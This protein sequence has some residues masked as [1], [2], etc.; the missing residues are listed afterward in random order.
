VA[1]GLGDIDRMHQRGEPVP[2]SL[3]V[4]VELRTAKAQVG[5]VDTVLNA[6]TRLFDVGGASALQEDRRLDRHWRNART[7]ASH[8]P[9]IYK[10]RAVGDHAINGT[11]PTFYWAVGSRAES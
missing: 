6:A 7:L 10:A 1:R 5:I 3:L 8:N 2:E 11:R 9:V 4:D